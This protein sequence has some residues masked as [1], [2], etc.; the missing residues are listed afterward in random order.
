MPGTALP[1]LTVESGK[2]PRARRGHHVV[3]P[4]ELYRV[5]PIE[6]DQAR[7]VLLHSFWGFLDA[8][9]AGRL[10]VKHLL[11]TLEHREIATFDVD[12]LLDYRARRPRMIFDG[13][14]Y[15]EVELPKLALYEVKDVAGL[16]FL[17]LA[18]PEPDF[19]WQQF[20]AAVRGLIDQLDVELTI[21]IAGVPWPAPHTRPIILSKHATDRRLLEGHMPWV[22]TMEVPGSIAGLLEFT[23]GQAGKTAMG[24]V[25]HV[26]HY[27]SQLDHPRAAVTL[28]EAV[29]ATTGLLFP[30][31][32]LRKAADEV[33]AEI[34]AQVENSEENL[35]QM[36]AL[37]RQYDA[38]LESRA[39]A[40]ATASGIPTADEIAAQ[41]EQFLADLGDRGD[42]ES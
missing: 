24:F 31:D 23:L 15:A 37:E 25:A 9:S 19:R 34:A 42:Q 28:L 14:H 3:S 32:A 30:L 41:V 10:A 26:P 16:P 18:G 22:G 6:P 8:G 17:V 7:R 5:E 21:S 11:D 36:R 12:V 33:D 13:D 39:G 4:E 35:V 27:L 29:S 40:T 2:C 1:I 38:L 20:V